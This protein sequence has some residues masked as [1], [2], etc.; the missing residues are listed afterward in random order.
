MSALPLYDFEIK[1]FNSESDDE[2]EIIDV[3][4]SLIAVESTPGDLGQNSRNTENEK[5]THDREKED[6][7][8]IV[9]VHIKDSSEGVT[10]GIVTTPMFENSTLVDVN[11]I[12]ENPL[13]NILKNEILEFRKGHNLHS[14]SVRWRQIDQISIRRQRCL[15]LMATLDGLKF[16]EKTSAAFEAA[17]QG[18]N[19]ASYEID[20]ILKKWMKTQSILSK[21]EKK[22]QGGKRKRSARK[23]KAKAVVCPCASSNAYCH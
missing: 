6:L 19:R 7:L 9:D 4:E 3:E 21:I 20:M 13:G 10:Y 1:F 23:R 2:V 8:K 16:C 18:Y 12:D 15:R 11:L 14:T 22:P 5:V 17:R